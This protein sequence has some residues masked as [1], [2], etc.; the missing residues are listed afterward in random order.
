[1]NGTYEITLPLPGGDR[2][3][4][5]TLSGQPER[6]S[7]TLTNPYAPTE[8]C[9]VEGKLEGGTLT[10][11]TMVG[12]T[13]FIL[14]GE[15]KPQGL[16]LTLTTHETIPLEP[17]KRL[18]GTPGHLEGEYL[19]GVYSPGG[20]KENHFVIRKENGALGGE[21]Y[22]LMDEKTLEFMKDM[23]AGGGPAGGGAPMPGGEMLPLPKLG[24]K[25]DMNPFLSVTGTPDAFTVT[26][27]TGN[28]S[29]FTFTGALEE[30]RPIL[31]LHV[32]DKTG[33]LRGIP[34]G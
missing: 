10:C 17:G 9:P 18:S 23:M 28:G 24:D 22:C 3:T 5:L 33:G 8:L 32:T 16:E 2:K 11:R 6:L 27:K 21:M 30:D 1:M 13:E 19:V 20:V 31:T 12:R 25:C 34:V 29:L 26:T 15:E 4:T 14:S 7:G